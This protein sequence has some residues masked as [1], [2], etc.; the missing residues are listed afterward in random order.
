MDTAGGGQG[1]SERPVPREPSK[2][3]LCSAGLTLTQ[4]MV[5]SLLRASSLPPLFLHSSQPRTCPVQLRGPDLQEPHQLLSLL[6]LDLAP[7]VPPLGSHWACPLA[8]SSP[9]ADTQ[10]PG[11]APHTGLWA[12]KEL[13]PGLTHV[14]P[15]STPHR[16]PG[17]QDTHLS[18]YR[19]Y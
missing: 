4:L 14:H 16:G 7:L 18:I 1:C 19:D 8:V 6:Q 10:H 11:S 9:W 17:N 2:P 5:R 3:Y 13:R 15:S 12:P